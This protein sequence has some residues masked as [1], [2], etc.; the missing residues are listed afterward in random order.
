LQIAS[1]KGHL[2]VV[3]FLV[4][5]GADVHAKSYEAMRLAR[6]NGHADVFQYLRMQ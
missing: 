2:E 1:E 4:E 5:N 3:R 6:S